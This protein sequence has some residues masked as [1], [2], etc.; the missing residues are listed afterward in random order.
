MKT[1]RVPFDINKAKAGA[2]IVTRNGS[3]VRITC[4]DVDAK[5][6]G[7]TLLVLARK[8][9]KELPYLC[10]ENGK[11]S[12]DES[13]ESELDLFIEEEEETDN[14]DP[15][16]A[17]VESIADM[18][19]RYSE[20]QSIEELKDFY[21]NV[22][23]KCQDA[24]DY[25]RVCMI[26]LDEEHDDVFEINPD[27]WYTCIKEWQSI[28]M[29][30]GDMFDEG[31]YYLG[32]DILKYKGLLEDGEDYRDYFRPW[33]IQDAKEGDVLYS[34]EVI[35]IFNRIKGEWIHCYC[36][37]HRDGSFISENYDLMHIKLCKEVQPAT[38]EQ[39]ELFFQKMKD[40]GYEWD[41]DK[42]ELKKI[43]KAKTRRMTNQELSW[44]LREHPEEHREMTYSDEDNYVSSDI[45]YLKSEANIQVYEKI[46]IRKNGGEWEEPLIN[47][48]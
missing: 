28:D 36:T 23:V 48:K 42:K 8:D 40:A 33:N 18:V 16:K 9:G 34:G 44:W 43:E 30:I 14:Y 20:L 32:S 31:H 45:S 37:L 17:T 2:K 5:V 6:E 13:K 35:F 24:F 4:T 7:F 19:E 38:K 21:N 27:K 29:K 12:L 11:A 41:S 10:R 15:Y 3:S 26:N 22:R 1:R 25:G 46:V 47:I 39:R